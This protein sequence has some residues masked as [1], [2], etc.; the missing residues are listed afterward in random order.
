MRPVIRVDKKI[1]ANGS[2]VPGTLENI[3]K[4]FS[5]KSATTKKSMKTT[6]AMKITAV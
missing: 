3:S 5:I 6:K 1:N 4:L 2:Q